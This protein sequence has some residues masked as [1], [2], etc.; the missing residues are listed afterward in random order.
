[1]TRRR[2]GRWL[3]RHWL[4]ACSVFF[5]GLVL[6]LGTYGFH[7]LG[8]EPWDAF[9]S[10]IQL[11]GLNYDVG[12]FT[13][14]TDGDA[15]DWTLQVARFLAPGVLIAAVVKL[16]ADGFGL[17]LRR[18]WHTRSTNY[19]RD[20]VIGF[21]PLGRE[22]GRRLLD[23]RRAITWI[24]R[25]SGD[26]EALRDA[27]EA[28]ERIGGVLLTG[29]PS[30]P[31]L[32]DAARITL[33]QR[34]FV[35]LAD[36]LASFDA[37]EAIRAHA[38]RL[39]DIRVFTENPVVAGSLTSAAEAGFVTGRGV[40]LFNIRAEA[41]R[42]LVRTAQWDRLA[43]IVGQ[44]RVHIVIAGFGWQGEALMEETLLL[45]NRAGLKPPLVTVIDQHAETA[46]ARVLRRSPALLS[47]DLDVEG[48]LPPRFIKAE[49]ETVDFAGLDLCETVHQQAVPVTAWVVCTGDDDLNL[50]T[51]LQLQSQI[52]G[53]QLAGAPI[54][55]RI[56]AGHAGESHTLGTDGITMSVAFGSL[57]AGLDQTSALERDPD[58][59]SKALHHAYLDAEQ[60]SAGLEGNNNDK[61][62]KPFSK[63]DAEQKWKELSPSKKN[64]NR[65]AHR[66][67]AMKIADLGYDW[68]NWESGPLPGLSLKQR[69]VWVKAQTTLAE[70]GF[71]ED[72]KVASDA[73]ESK[74]AAQLLEVMIQEHRRWTIDRAIDGWRWAEDRDESRLLQPYLVRW[75]ALKKEIRAYDA[76]QVRA[77]VDRPTHAGMSN[78]LIRN[79]IRISLPYEAGILSNA[80]ISDWPLATEFQVLLPAGNLKRPEKTTFDLVAER[81][82]QGLADKLRDVARGGTL[83]RL[84]LIFPAPP[85]PPVLRLANDLAKAVSTGGATV[86]AVWAW[87]QGADTSARLPDWVE[88]ALHDVTSEVA[89]VSEDLSN[90][91][92]PST[93]EIWASIFPGH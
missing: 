12:Q 46:R 47:S 21:G 16:L 49:L 36:D 88:T 30:D 86:T 39:K 75:S 34:A 2:S 72:N 37:A 31:R 51:A 48:W 57:T 45:C 92:K 9:Y 40:E 18:V 71:E 38:P 6:A 74:Q 54:H 35:A 79:S 58:R 23:Q 55:V 27:R 53:R 66:H 50:R 17:W 87:N 93:R 90:A 84:F 61:P 22:I 15:I 8:K 81:N 41:V 25:I 42:R 69:D 56:W 80:A 77:F 64:A 10:A 1:M 70:V 82:Y 13:D 20:V 19:P 59:Q 4:W 7:K 26:D 52:Q 83:C 11:F 62:V 28:A 33:A 63:D 32:L 24:D 68:K 29:D 78:A 67:A 5:V 44:D 43:G 65:R 3:F 73:I 60:V 89:P 91:R 14:E 85:T 76:V